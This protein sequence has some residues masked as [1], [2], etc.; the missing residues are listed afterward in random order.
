MKTR[1]RRWR[2][3]LCLLFAAVTLPAAATEFVTLSK[4]GDEVLTYCNPRCKVTSLPG[5][6]GYE[7]VAARSAPLIYNDVTIGTVQEKVWRK[8][9]H[10]K[11]HIFGLR[12]SLNANEWDSSGAAFNVNDLFRQVKPNKKVSVAYFLDGATRPLRKAGRT[13]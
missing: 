13:V 9:S 7:L 1:E 5:E 4:T 10:P 2:A 8:Q 12:I 11:V 3:V 6:P